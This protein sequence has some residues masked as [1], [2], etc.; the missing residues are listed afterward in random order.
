MRGLVTLSRSSMFDVS[1]CPVFRPSELTPKPKTAAANAS[2]IA[3][4]LM[5]GTIRT[6]PIPMDKSFQQSSRRRHSVWLRP[7][8]VVL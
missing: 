1:A 2:L 6:S 7:D 8:R 5:N 3:A 4:R